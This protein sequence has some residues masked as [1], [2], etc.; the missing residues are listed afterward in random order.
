MRQIFF[1]WIMRRL[2]QVAGVVD[3]K[4]RPTMVNKPMI[5]VIAIPFRIKPG[6][7]LFFVV[8]MD[9]PPINT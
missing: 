4:R 5:N 6:V 9:K 7:N 1:G 8:K 2:R 3:E